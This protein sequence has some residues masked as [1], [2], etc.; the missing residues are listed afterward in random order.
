MFISS[1]FLCKLYRETKGRYCEVCTPFKERGEGR[2]KEREREE[3]G[4]GGRLGWWAGSILLYSYG[5]NIVVTESRAP[6]SDKSVRLE[7]KLVVVIQ[8]YAIHKQ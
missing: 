6:S 7:N 5:K 2:G 4:E 8:A 1:H 3:E